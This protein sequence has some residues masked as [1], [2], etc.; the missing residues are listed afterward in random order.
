MEPTIETFRKSITKRLN[1][2]PD[3]IKNTEYLHYILWQTILECNSL[4]FRII[5][6]KILSNSQIESSYL[7]FDAYIIAIHEN[8]DSEIQNLI[9]KYYQNLL[10]ELIILAQN[11]ELFEVC[12]NLKSFQEIY[13]KN[14]PKI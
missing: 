4:I 13:L 6:K 1:H 8:C 2:I 12:Y 3:W 11:D 7:D 5:K 14:Y 9:S 10:H